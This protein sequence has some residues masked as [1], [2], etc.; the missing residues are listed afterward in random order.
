[1]F[2]RQGCGFGTNIGHGFLEVQGVEIREGPVQVEG[3]VEI[4]ENPTVIEDIAEILPLA[5]AVD[6]SDGL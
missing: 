4:L 5:E 2:F 6:P 1:M 3:L